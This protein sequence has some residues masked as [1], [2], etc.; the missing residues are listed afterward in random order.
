[1]A[2]GGARPT[3]QVHAN[4][5]AL[6]PGVTGTGVSG[7][8]ASFGMD[9]EIEIRWVERGVVPPRCRKPRDVCHE[10][11]MVVTVPE[12]DCAE[13]PV[14]LRCHDR[15]F[16]PEGPMARVV[17]LRWWRDRLW[18]P[19]WPA[20]G[21]GQVT[22]TDPLL[23]R[24]QLVTAGHTWGHDSEEH[25]AAVVQ[26][27]ANERP[28]I[29]G[30]PYEPA[31]EPIYEVIT[32][33]GASH[34]SVWIEPTNDVKRWRVNFGG[35]GAHDWFSALEFEAAVSMARALGEEGFDTSA[36]PT[37]PP[38]EVVLPDA[39][40]RAPRAEAARARRR[41]AAVAVGSLLTGAVDELRRVVAYLGEAGSADLDTLAAAIEEVRG[42]LAGLAEDIER[43]KEQ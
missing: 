9:F 27:R 21:D 14:A 16:G 7:P 41:E 6:P 1:M 35:T 34:A 12:I 42:S 43:V 8:G 36:L 2:P 3:Y 19:F 24:R 11:T 28:F 32:S 29:G 33:R 4:C 30:V 18:K 40:R 25:A 20:G 5:A 13:A 22:S 38:I 31:T 10:G 17:E 23:L 37:A 26:R 39:V 15:A